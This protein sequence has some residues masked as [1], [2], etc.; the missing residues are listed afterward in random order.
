MIVREHPARD[1]LRLLIW[2]P[3]RWFCARAPIALNLRLFAAMGRLHLAL[4]AT[5]RAQLRALFARAYPA[6]D[7][8]RI[9]ACSRTYLINHYVDR[10]SI[11]HYHRLRGRALSRVIEIAGR[12]R[13]DAALAESR[14]CVLVH[15]HLGPS[16]LPLVALGRLGYP[17]TQ[18]GLRSARG[19]SFIGRRVQLHHR[20]RLEE[21]FPA[22]MIYVARFQRQL[23]RSLAAGRVLMM[24]GDGTGTAER[25]GHH[26]PHACC[27]H[28]LE[29]PLGPFRLAQSA[30]APLR[31]L[32]LVRDGAYR[33]RAVIESPPPGAETPEQL[34]QAFVARLRH[35]IDSDPGLWQFWD[36]FAAAA[37]SAPSISQSTANT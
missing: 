33:Y 16:Q 25:Y 12:D 32:F 20:L 10:L 2:Y 22:E 7:A 3:L 18:L 29:L 37:A 13:L 4:S 21:A 5:R 11:F 14:G 8:A 23:Y 17:M 27:G 6:A 34:Q 1:L 15:A 31:F 30:G 24:A 28:T 36:Q 9:A 19:L 35:W 26:L